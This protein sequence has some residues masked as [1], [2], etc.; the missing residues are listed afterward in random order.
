MTPGGLTALSLRMLT[1]HGQDVTL[2]AYTVG[3]YDPAT[4]A[5]TPSTADTT[6]RGAILPLGGTI[7]IRGTLIQ[8]TDKRL[9]LDAEG[10]VSNQD[11]LIVGTVDYSIVSLEAVDYKGTTVLYDLH[12]RVGA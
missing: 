7:Q 3:A 11:H 9:L 1:T 8:A 12:L 4:G 6:R 2:R 5:S 10:E